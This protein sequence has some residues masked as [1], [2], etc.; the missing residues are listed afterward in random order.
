MKN[1]QLDFC[2]IFECEGC[3]F[4]GIK[5]CSTQR[6]VL[7]K[8]VKKPRRLEFL[9]LKNPSEK[10]SGKNKEVLGFVK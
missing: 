7:C 10:K 4:N 3:V 9:L 2:D 6:G 1:L 8:Q 5:I